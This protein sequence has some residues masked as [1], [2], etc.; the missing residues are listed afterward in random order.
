MTLKVFPQYARR[1]CRH[2]EKWRQSLGRWTEQTLKNHLDAAVRTASAIL[3]EN[4]L[5]QDRKRLVRCLELLDEA[6]RAIE[7]GQWIAEERVDP[8]LRG[9]DSAAEAPRTSGLISQRLASDPIR[10]AS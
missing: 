1:H 5:A 4:Y 6:G 10:Q 3:A 8:P 2:S 7:G 9:A